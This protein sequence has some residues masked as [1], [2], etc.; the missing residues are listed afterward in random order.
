MRVALLVAW[1]C[2]WALGCQTAGGPDLLTLSEVGP[3]IVSAGDRLELRGEGFPEGRPATVVFRGELRRP[4]GRPITDVE[5]VATALAYSPTTAAL[6]VDDA[7]ARRFVG[8]GATAEHTTFR[9][10]VRIVF[11]ARTATAPPVAGTRHGVVLDV[12]PPERG[13]LAAAHDGAGQELLAHLGVTAAAGGPKAPLT[14]RAVLPGGLADRA[15][16]R[17]GD[18]LVGFSG[19]TVRG[20]GDL[21]V[22]RGTRTAVLWVGRPGLDAPFRVEVDV[23][24]LSPLAPSDLVPAA[25][26]LGAL[27]LL[28]VLRAGP[29]P[30]L[31]AWFD[32]GVGL[33]ATQGLGRGAPRAEQVLAWLS[34][35]GRAGRAPSFGVPLAAFLAVVSVFTVIGFGR[36]VVSPEADLALLY[37]ASLVVLLAGRL[38]EGGVRRGRT[39]SLG[40]GLLAVLATLLVVLPGLVGIGALTIA[41]ESVSLVEIARAQ[42]GAPWRWWG[43]DN[44]G[45]A[46][47]AAAL[48]LSA[49]PVGAG[50]TAP[51]GLLE[52]AAAPGEGPGALVGF[53]RGCEWLH[54][55]TTAALAVALYAG[56]WRVPLLSAVWA[57]SLG[58]LTA[59]AALFVAKLWAA[60]LLVVA[61]RAFVARLGVRPLAR[62]Y[63]GAV[64][65]AALAAGVLAVLWAEAA[66]RL[67]IPAATVGTLLLVVAVGGAASLLVRAGGGP[68]KDALAGSVNPWL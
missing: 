29:L 66:L 55:W 56:G 32:R 1:A 49:V 42:G 53:G 23:A 39:W 30:I 27:V 62:L 24:A 67:E 46:V 16:L 38:A 36:T 63:A 68:G 9:G 13:E 21:A 6:T 34:P 11:A 5:I 57:P 41:A 40:S 4:G 58:V 17:E 8:S 26:L 50:R 18:V 20:V 14:V 54:A 19:V 64:L 2:L 45:L 12:L 3:A 37:G 60:M 47:S 7:V 25:L 52:G 44:P 31:G 65:P 33:A 61:A 28:L 22:P 10:D 35:M 48:L 43:L 51:F 15:G 59:G